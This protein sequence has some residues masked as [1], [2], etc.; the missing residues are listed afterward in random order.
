MRPLESRDGSGRAFITSPS[1]A[2]LRTH[3]LPAYLHT[4]S[5]K[6]N[7]RSN[8]Q[9]GTASK[10]TT[11]TGRTRNNHGIER[12]SPNPHHMKRL[13]VCRETLAFRSGN[14]HCAA[15]R[16]RHNTRGLASGARSTTAASDISFGFKGALPVAARGGAVP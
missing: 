16:I 4:I 9:F 6:S 11:R 15:K 7:E 2:K 5:R 8:V 12:I 1:V 10:G 13:R 14:T 3:R